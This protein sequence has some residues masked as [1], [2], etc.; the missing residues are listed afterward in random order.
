MDYKDLTAILIKT[1]ATVM[2]FYFAAS[3]PAAIWGIVIAFN[4]GPLPEGAQPVVWQT[5]LS[6]GLSVAGGMA[7]AIFVFLFP[8]SV[9][10][11]LIQGEPLSSTPNAMLNVQVAA[12]RIIGIYYIYRSIVD[13]AYYAGRIY[14]RYSIAGGTSGVAPPGTYTPEDVA[15]LIS[16]SIEMC[17]AI[18]L[19]LGARG[20]L[21]LIDRLRGRADA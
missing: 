6:T 7:I 11:K 21:G 10:N 16:T 4:A 8:R 12:L 15:G 5:A 18:C 2:L 3:V 1:A 19:V 9:A 14:V 13:A 17:L 20:L